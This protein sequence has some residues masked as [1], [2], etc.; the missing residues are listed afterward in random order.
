MRTPSMP[1][2]APACARPTFLVGV[3]RSTWRHVA[4]L[5]AMHRRTGRSAGESQTPSF[6]L[7]LK[8]LTA[9]AV[10]NGWAGK[11]DLDAPVTTYLPGSALATP[12]H[13]RRSPCATCLHQDVGCRLRGR[14]AC[15]TTIKAVRRSKK[16]SRSV[17]GAAQPASG[18]THEYATRL[19]HPSL[20]VQTVSGT[21][22]R[23][24]SVRDLRP[25]R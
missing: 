3:G 4:Y 12:P 19:Q 21:S 8:I 23:T 17:Q 13:P 1:T 18:P 9:L 22:T 2:S 5:K 14:R 24:T 16:A 11:I 10:C 25:F 15:R 20:I 7:D 6:S